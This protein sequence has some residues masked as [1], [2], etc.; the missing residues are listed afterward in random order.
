[1]GII[2]ESIQYY[3]KLKEEEKQ[4]KR[5][6]KSELDYGALQ[7]MIDRAEDNPDLRINITLNNG[8]KME[9][10]SHKKHKGQTFSDFI[11]GEDDTVLEIN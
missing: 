2:K 9:I 7:Y 3:K 10:T 6:V 8:T 5:L 4:R 11:N 1:M